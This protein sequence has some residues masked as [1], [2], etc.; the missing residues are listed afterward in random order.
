MMSTGTELKQHSL[1]KVLSSLDI[2]EG[3]RI[4]CRG[5]KKMFVNRRP[6][7]IYVAQTGDV[8]YYFDSAVQVT[9]L[10][11]KVFGKKYSAWIY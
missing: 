4:E 7:G 9:R 11:A 1:G 3:V 6:S 8:F 10:V 2:D 5:K